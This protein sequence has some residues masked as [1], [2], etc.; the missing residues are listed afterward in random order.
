VFEVWNITSNPINISTI[1]DD[2]LQYSS[3]CE[4]NDTALLRDYNSGSIYFTKLLTDGKLLV[5]NSFTGVH[6]FFTDYCV[7]FDIRTNDMITL[8]CNTTKKCCPENESYVSGVCQKSNETNSFRT[9]ILL[10]ECNG[11]SM[12]ANHSQI[13]NGVFKREYKFLDRSYAEYYDDF[14]LEDDVDKG[15]V[16]TFC[17]VMKKCCPP[18]QSRKESEE[19]G[20]I[21]A[22]SES[23][24]FKIPVKYQRYKK[25]DNIRTD[26]E[27]SKIKF[28]T[29]DQT[30]VTKS[31]NEYS[32]TSPKLVLD[33][34]DDSTCMEIFEH[35]NDIVVLIESKNDSGDSDIIPNIASMFFISLEAVC[36][37]FLV[38][39]SIIY[40]VVPGLNNMHGR[41][42]ATHTLLLALGFSGCEMRNTITNRHIQNFFA[43]VSFGAMA[44]L[45]VV[46]VFNIIILRNKEIWKEWGT[47]CKAKELRLC[48]IFGS[49]VV[50]FMAVDWILIE[51]LEKEFFQIC[52]YL[53][54]I[55]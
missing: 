28:L 40:S 21:C 19:F 22:T 6:S 9:N 30:E 48:V 2:S 13:I 34:N 27:I 4:P 26:F 53:I 38:I 8:L 45:L 24:N 54:R 52:K 44:S 55:N 15:L 18:G 20:L 43:V 42:L 33:F 5:R 47:P 36:T 12:E 32:I 10:N 35:E 25:Q 23:K 7:D 16:I 37:V 31:V 3:I 49:I 11:I 1:S 29:R 51:I 17:H 39:T 14:C 41:F 50:S 46:W